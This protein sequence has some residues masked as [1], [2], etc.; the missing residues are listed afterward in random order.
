MTQALEHWPG[1]ERNWTQMIR[2]EHSLLLWLMQLAVV[3][4]AGVASAV[5]ASALQAWTQRIR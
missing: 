4:S 5:V 2:L 1:T 3:A